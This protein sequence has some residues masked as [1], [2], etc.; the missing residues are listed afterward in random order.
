V[1]KLIEL[2]LASTSCDSFQAHGPASATGTPDRMS[3]CTSSREKSP[4]SVTMETKCY[5]LA[6]PQVSRRATPNRSNGDACILEIG[7]RSETDIGYYSDI[8][9]VALADGNP[10][11]YTRRDSTPYDDIKRRGPA[12]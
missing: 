8:D 3:S 7:T 2:N 1:I 11:T 5:G 12:I 6:T 4:L 9:M 10:A